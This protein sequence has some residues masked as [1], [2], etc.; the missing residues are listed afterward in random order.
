MWSCELSGKFWSTKGNRVQFSASLLSHETTAAL[1]HSPEVWCGANADL[2]D[3]SSPTVFGL[4]WPRHKAAEA[5]IHEHM[6]QSELSS[7]GFLCRLTVLALCPLSNAIHTTFWHV[8]ASVFWPS[9][10]NVLLSVLGDVLSSST[11]H[12]SAPVGRPVRCLHVIKDHA[13]HNSMCFQILCV[14]ST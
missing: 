12:K 13:A 5:Q 4:S 2:A 11:P 7:P 9:L 14:S 6:F 10:L 3:Y 1:Q 8:G